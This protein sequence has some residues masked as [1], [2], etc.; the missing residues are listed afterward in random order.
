MLPNNPVE[1]TAGSYLRVSKGVRHYEWPKGATI[2]YVHGLGPLE[3]IYVN[4]ADDPRQKSN[5]K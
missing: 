3:T 5:Q 1:L 2:I 4:P